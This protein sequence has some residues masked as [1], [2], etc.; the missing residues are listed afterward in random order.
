[1]EDL[2]NKIYNDITKNEELDKEICNVCHL[3]IKSDEIKLPCS[4]YYHFKCLK[5]K[6][7]HCPYCMETYKISQ[8]DIS[9]NI[10]NVIIKSGKRKG[11]TCGR[12][13]C[14]YHKSI[15]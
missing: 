1:M 4:H 13:Y 11:E 3:K 9:K 5:K 8:N 2:F 6:V 10:C 15:E 7:G 14:G 12:N